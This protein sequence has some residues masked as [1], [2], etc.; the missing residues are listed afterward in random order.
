MSQTLRESAPEQHYQKDDHQYQ[1]KTTAEVMVWR[2]NIEAT[3]TK[4]ENQ[5][6]QE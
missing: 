2:T 1:A 5:D 4:K 6:N 3:P